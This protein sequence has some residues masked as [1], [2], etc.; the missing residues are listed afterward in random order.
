[1][2]LQDKS[3]DHYV[4]VPHECIYLQTDRP[5]YAAGDTVWFR[6]HLV[7]V[8]TSVPVSRSRFV[9]VE[10]HDQQADTL[11]QRI[12]VKS[13]GDGVFANALLL[14]KQ[15]KAGVYTLAAY[16]QWM[17]N[18]PTERFCYRPL[19][20]GGGLSIRGHRIPVEHLSQYNAKVSISGQAV[21]EKAPM[22]LHI[23]VH[24]HDGQP[25][26][27]HFALSVTDYEVVKPDS[28]FGDIRQS[29]LRQRFYGSVDTLGSITY[30][31]QEQQLITGR[32]KGSLGQRIKNPHLLVVNTR[33]GHRQ[34]FEL[35]DS[36]R[37]ALAVDNP[38]GTTFQLEGTRR[39][40]RTTFVRLQID[41]LTFP[42]LTLPQYALKA[43]PELTA[44]NTQA[45]MQQMYSRAEYIE[46]PEVE[47]VGKK[48]QVQRRNTMALEAP[49]GFNVGDPWIERASTLRQLLARLGINS[50]IDAWGREHING[51]GGNQYVGKVYVDNVEYNIAEEDCD[52][53]N[54]PPQNISSIEYFPTN[55]AQNAIFGVR[56]IP[57][58][59][60]IPGV[61][62]IF[63]KDGSEIVHS[64][65]NRPLSMA[66]VRQLGYEPPVEFY[67]PQY[68][69]ADKS[70]YTRPDYRTTLYWNPK[71]RIDETGETTVTFYASD[72]SKRYLVT[73]EGVSDDGTVVSKQVVIE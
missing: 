27:G 52:V 33:T 37:F 70:Q 53:L 68:P 36:T 15:M 19:V 14:P 69:A 9:Y 43:S 16:T 29:L 30:P 58:S 23:A 18:F 38:N 25:L 51:E 55:Y 26:S 12:M 21:A 46:L 73:L 41:S 10:L 48:P 56:P 35:G 4:M 28:L 40:G 67:S 47:K 50:Y 49:K 6:A 13:D 1:M 34:E 59:G 62:F 32:V 60:I 57:W 63:L 45:Q 22:M 2:S 61:L 65:G 39:N 7:D 31:Y 8:A 64:K 54:I 71:V 66:T 42:R 24:D 17:R 5:Y 3:H 44:F 20:V 72:V 11:M